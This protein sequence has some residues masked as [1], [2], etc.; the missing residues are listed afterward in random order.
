M[1][2]ALRS[3]RYFCLILNITANANPLWVASLSA[4]LQVM[5]ILLCSLTLRPHLM[6]VPWA[7]HWCPYIILRVQRSRDETYLFDK[8]LSN[9]K[10]PVT[11][12]KGQI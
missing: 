6:R 2:I 7:L 4:Y 5:S 11:L 8:I 9:S 10:G 1:Q 12:K 3:N